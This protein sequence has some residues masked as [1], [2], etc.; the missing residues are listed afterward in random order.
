MKV[1]WYNTGVQFFGKII[2]AAST[3]VAT[4]LIANQYGAEGFGQF[5]Q[6][7]SFVA[8]F[9]L[10]PDFGLNAVTLRSITEN[11]HEREKEFRLLYGLRIVLSLVTMFLAI[12]LLTFFP[13]NSQTAV[14]FSPFVKVGIIFLSVTVLTQSL[15]RTMNVLFQEKL[16]YDFSVFSSILSNI[17]TLAGTYL[18]T[19]LNLS[20]LLV[21]AVNVLSSFILTFFSIT[22]ARLYVDTMHPLFDFPSWKRILRKAL[23]LGLTLI[24]NVIYFRIDVFLLSFYRDAFEVGVYG[25]AY[26][27]FEF[28]LTLPV[29][30]MNAMYPI[31][32]QSYKEKKTEPFLKELKRASLLLFGISVIF[33]VAGYFLAPLIPW[34][35]QN[36]EFVSSVSLFR[37]LILSLPVFFLTPVL[38]WAMITVSLEWQLILVYFVSALLNIALNLFLIPLFGATAAAVTTVVCESF[39]L[40]FSYLT[41]VHIFRSKKE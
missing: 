34:L 17:V 9:Y 2:S 18:V 26:K 19:R 20:L 28:P 38:M 6:I 10:F 14:G 5:T 22:L 11:E 24:L 7:L 37:I 4:V 15:F 1:I 32:L 40:F 25:L 8:F 16:R 41:L 21:V 33:L 30:F 35:T 39:T 29:F 31:F 3:L 27:F 36:T 23:P 13:Y 12:S